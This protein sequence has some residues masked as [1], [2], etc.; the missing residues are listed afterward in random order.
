M[1]YDDYDSY[2]EKFE[3]MKSPTYYP[4]VEQIDYMQKDP[5]KWLLFA[6][7]LYERG[8]KPK[9]KEEEY[10]KKTLLMFINEHLE[11]VDEQSE[12]QNPVLIALGE[13]DSVGKEEC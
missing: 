6:C 9:N 5:G 11:L 12:V 1:T 13:Q 3:T 7:Y 4:G 10:N 2:L 8:H